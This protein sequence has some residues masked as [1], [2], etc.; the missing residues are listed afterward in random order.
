MVI[1]GLEKLLEH[2]LGWP[3]FLIGE[4]E[5]QS[6]GLSLVIIGFGYSGLKASLY[7]L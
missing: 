3:S 4:E 5:S 7:Y 1:S 2:G 6:A